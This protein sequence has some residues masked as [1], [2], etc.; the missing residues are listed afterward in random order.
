MDNLRL[1]IEAI[2]QTI[3]NKKVEHLQL[4]QMAEDLMKDE[5]TPVACLV[6]ISDEAND[7]IIE[8]YSL[9]NLLKII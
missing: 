9:E 5:N 6:E 7:L 8:I 3:A 1:D 2:K 4:C